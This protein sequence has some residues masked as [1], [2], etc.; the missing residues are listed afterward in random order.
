MS[1]EQSGP[2]WAIDTKKPEKE[3]RFIFV[4]GGEKNL[5]LHGEVMLHFPSGELFKGHLTDNAIIEGSMVFRHDC[6]YV[7]EV[8]DLHAEGRGHFE[9]GDSG[10]AY[11]GE[12]SKSLP[13]GK[14]K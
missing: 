10:Y 7:G 11:E 9:N 13:H 12:W 6:F 4:R 1:F 5:R 14:G 8:K 2:L 3:K